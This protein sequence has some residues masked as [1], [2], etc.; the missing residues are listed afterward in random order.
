MI[1]PTIVTKKDIVDGSIT[2]PRR[3]RYDQPTTGKYKSTRVWIAFPASNTLYPI[4]HSLR[5]VPTIWTVISCY[6]KGASA[7]IVY[8]DFPLPFSNYV[9]CFKCNTAGAFAE[10]ELR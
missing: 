8:T 6:A 7:P 2:M 3:V 1:N 4:P 10:I 9:A 5:K